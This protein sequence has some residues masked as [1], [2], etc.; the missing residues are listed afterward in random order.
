MNQGLIDSKSKL[1]YSLR[2]G[3]KIRTD[4][5]GKIFGRL[6]VLSYAGT[7]KGKIATWNCR[8]ICGTLRIVYADNLTGKKIK[9][10]GCLRREIS[11]TRAKKVRLNPFG[12]GAKFI[13]NKEDETLWRMQKQVRA[14]RKILDQEIRDIFGFDKSVPG[15]RLH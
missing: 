6:T 1:V 3:K 12:R 9:S 11:G 5:A 15:P 2:V 14:R 4:L 13:N 7:V 8:C 10:C